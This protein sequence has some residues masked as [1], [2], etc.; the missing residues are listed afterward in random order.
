MLS[1]AP[2]RS[3]ANQRPGE[4]LPQTQRPDQGQISDRAQREA[5]EQA[6]GRMNSQGGDVD[7]RKAVSAG[8]V[9]ELGRQQVDAV[10]SDLSAAG[11]LKPDE[12]G[13]LQRRLQ[14]DVTNAARGID[15]EHKQREQQKKKTDVGAETGRADQE[16]TRSLFGRSPEADPEQRQNSLLARKELTPTDPA[17][18][19]TPL[20]RLGKSLVDLV[21]QAREST[22]PGFGEKVAP[23]TPERKHE[24]VALST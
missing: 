4:D 18:V 3:P 20:H 22:P 24:E 1:Q 2:N 11:L 14:Q 12:V 13:P 15:A 23:A 7:T 9:A 21:V 8:H 19:T 17:P 10:L 5:L 6:N 16:T